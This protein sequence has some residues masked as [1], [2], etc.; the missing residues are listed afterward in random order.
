MKVTEVFLR[1]KYF[2]FAGIVIEWLYYVIT[3][4]KKRE[5]DAMSRL[6]YQTLR[7]NVVDAIREKI[8]KRELEPGAR[9]VEKELSE[10]FGVSRGPIR[11]A[12]RQLEQEG[13]IE[14][15]RNVGC[16]VKRVTIKD[17]YEIYLL[18]S[19]YEVLAVRM[20]AGRMEESDIAEMENIL[21]KMDDPAM[22]Y[23]K[24]SSYDRMFHKR[25]VDRANS[26][27]LSKVWTDLDYGSVVEFYM[28]NFDEK[29]IAQRQYL[30]HKELLDACKT[31]EAEV[32]CG[33]ISRH[34]MA[35]VSRFL[36]KEGIKEE[37]FCFW[38]RPYM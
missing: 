6:V 28:G 17:L 5:H 26:E 12:L 36:E 21:E 25:I 20:C 10:E 15:T 24:I 19:T 2:P 31:K 14:Y 30:I 9:I 32:I 23:A 18:R 37:E 38:Q 35:S 13:I 8:L 4:L 33:A 16:S 22:G 34:Y 11:E 27:R 29:E 1:N 3:L 7:E